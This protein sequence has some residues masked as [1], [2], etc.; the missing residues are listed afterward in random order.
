MLASRGLEDAGAVLMGALVG[1]DL[2]GAV[3]VAL[4]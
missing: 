4:G 2:L 3:A 1:A